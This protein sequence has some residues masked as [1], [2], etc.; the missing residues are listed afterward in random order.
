MKKLFLLLIIGLAGSFASHAQSFRAKIADST[1]TNA[2]TSSFTIPVTGAKGT[3][4]FQYVITKTSGTVAGTIVLLGTV[5][6]TNYVTLNTYTLTDATVT[7]G[8]TYAYNPYAKYKV[9]VTT[10]GTQVSNYKI[11]ALYR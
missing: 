5:D 3:V 8:V 6:G 9:T 11:W 10:T 7:T 2:M 1:H 4:T